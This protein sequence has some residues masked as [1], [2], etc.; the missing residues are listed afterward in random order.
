MRDLRRRSPSRARAI[1]RALIRRQGSTTATRVTVHVTDKDGGSA[2]KATTVTVANVAPT[3]TL[4]N[5]G[6]VNEGSPA[7]ISFSSPSDPSSADTSAGFHYSYAC[8]GLATSLATTYAGATD[9]TSKQCTFPDG[10][11]SHL[12]KGRI[13]DKNG[14]STTYDTTVDV[15]NVAPNVTAP[16]NQSAT[17]GS[18]SSFSLGSFTDPGP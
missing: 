16:A 3:A 9:G 12:V 13:F 14:G 6:P 10:P 7:T 17:E 1:R 11:S 8:D 5:N 18:G 15:R 4:A 2:Q